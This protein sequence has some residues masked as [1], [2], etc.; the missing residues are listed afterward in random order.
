MGLL[1]EI[2]S[3]I[4]GYFHNLKVKP[5]TIVIKDNQGNYFSNE[6][7][8]VN[9]DFV[10][11][12][13]N[14]RLWKGV[15]VHHSATTDQVTYDWDAIRKYHMSWRYK[16]RVIAEPEARRLIAAGV[17]GVLA[18]WR[19][20]AYNFGEELVGDSY[21]Y[22]LG[23]SLSDTGSHCVGYNQKY[24]GIVLIG[25]YD[26]IA[27]L[28]IQYELLINLIKK[29]MTFFKFPAENV[30]GHW[31]TFIKLGQAKTKE[32]AWIKFKTCPGKLCSMDRIRN[33]LK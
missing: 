4:K 6:K 33:A 21:K 20:V 32:E 10:I 27:P 18:P 31:E 11:D 8:L 25:N 29:L 15:V 2:I 1:T 16:D 30:I 5:R 9:Q 13:K 19:D 23:R 14:S 3:L 22:C 7:I 26:S 12:V 17:K 28:D 24:I